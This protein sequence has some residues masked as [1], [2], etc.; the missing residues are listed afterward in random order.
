MATLSES[1][2]GIL[3]STSRTA[4]SFVLPVISATSA[5]NFSVSVSLMFRVMAGSG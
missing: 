4:S 5:A 1:V 2:E 3:G